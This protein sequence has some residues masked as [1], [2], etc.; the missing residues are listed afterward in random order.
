MSHSTKV[1]LVLALLLVFSGL[2]SSAENPQ[3]PEVPK[4]QEAPSSPEVALSTN[5]TQAKEAKIAQ[6]KERLA[7]LETLYIK[8]LQG[9]LK[10]GDSTP[11]DF[12][13]RSSASKNPMNYEMLQDGILTLLQINSA[14]KKTGFRM[15][16]FPQGRIN[17][18]VDSLKAMVKTIKACGRH[19]AEGEM[20]L[21]DYVSRIQ[22][23]AD[24]FGDLKSQKD[25]EFGDVLKRIE[26]NRE[27]NKEVLRS[28]S[29]FN[30]HVALGSSFREVL[31]LVLGSSSKEKTKEKPRI[32]RKDDNNIPE[33]IKEKLDKNDERKRGS[34]EDIRRKGNP[35]LDEKIKKREEA[36]KQKE[37]DL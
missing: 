21:I 6:H 15:A 34:M 4:P 7:F 33:K 27:P 8:F 23:V 11:L 10:K 22:Q 12:Q 13:C 19:W 5:E 20:E 14:K 28:G 17:V 36:R 31:D 1:F 3:T 37:K 16:G 18:L 30:D 24:F 29:K 32:I 35:F 26:E 25:I 2:L 9:L